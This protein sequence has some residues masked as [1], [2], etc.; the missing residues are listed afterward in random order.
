M[1]PVRGMDRGGKVLVISV[2][3][4]RSGRIPW[5]GD[6]DAHSDDPAPKDDVCAGWCLHQS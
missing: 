6:G 4:A 5:N 3:G 1:S 2:V